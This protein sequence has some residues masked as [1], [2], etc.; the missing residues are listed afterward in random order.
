MFEKRLAAVR[1]QLL[2]QH[3]DYLCLVP[4]YNL[5]YLTGAEFMLL[6]R[7]FLVFIP[8]DDN[9]DIVL[10][11]PELEWPAWQREVPAEVRAFTWTDEKGPDEAMRGVAEMLVGAKR[12]AAE[13]LRMRLLEYSL[14]THALPDIEITEAESVMTPV[15]VR[16]D[17]D[18]IASHR[19]AISIAEKALADVLAEV[20]PG[21][22]ERE[23]CSRLTAAMLQ[24]CGET[25]PI[26]P[27]IQSGPNSAM[28]HGRTT[29]RVIEED[30]ILLI[31]FVT[32][33]NGYFSDITRT[34]VVGEEPDGKLREIY[35][36]VQA[37]NAGGRETA[38][39]G[40]SCQDVDRAVR[41]VIE[42]A[43]YGEYFVHRTGHGLGLDV[44]EDPGIV[45]GNETLLEQGMVFTIEPGIYIPGWGGIR[46]EDNVVL[47]E[48]GCDSMSTFGRDLQSVGV[49]GNFG[50]SDA[51]GEFGTQDS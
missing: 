39:P 51:Y 10:V 47:T 24:G 3:I 15:R 34:F 25:V 45:E 31:D 4:G 22:T 1:T 50:I 5:T 36:V 42:G 9:A 46:I 23:I 29:E 7:A 28:P 21:M 16:K 38:R 32:T 19:R 43:G 11:M 48:T 13:Y 44:H 2:A 8:A 41:K 27:L 14:L 33:V 12:V 37:A 18:E 6:E 20:R 17:A 49:K 30:D 35:G 40:V 26:E